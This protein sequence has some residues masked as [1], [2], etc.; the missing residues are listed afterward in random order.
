MK[1]LYANVCLLDTKTT[2]VRHEEKILQLT[3][4][5]QRAGLMK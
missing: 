4:I 2:K 3:P 5:F 1:K